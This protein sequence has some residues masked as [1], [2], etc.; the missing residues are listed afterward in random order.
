[1]EK[2]GRVLLWVGVAL[3]LL[4]IWL[5]AYYPN[6]DGPCHVANAVTMTDMWAHKNSVYHSFYTFNY[7]PSPNWLT[8]LALVALQ[9]LFSGVVAEKILLSIYV[10]FMVAGAR[11]L[12]RQMGN[13]IPLWPLVFLL[14][15]FHNAVPGGFYNFS[16]SVAFYM[17]LMAAWLSF[18]EKRIWGKAAVYFLLLAL[19]YF[20]HPVSFVFGCFS[21]AALG[22]TYIL[23]GQISLRRGEWRRVLLVLSLSVAPF[24]LM[25]QRFANDMGG[26][27]AIKTKFS[28]E[29][30]KDLAALKYLVNYSHKEEDVLIGIGILFCL[31][32]VAALVFRFRGKF[33][34]HHYDGFLL[35]LFFAF[36]VFLILPDAMLH[37]GYFVL[38]AGIFILLLVCICCAYIPLPARLLNG[39][40]ILLYALFA[41]LFF[42][43]MP[44]VF[45]AADAIADHMSAARYIKRG[46]VIL[47]LNYDTWGRDRDG[48]VITSRNNIFCH[49]AQYLTT[50]APTLVLDNYE[51]NTGYFP[52]NWRPDLDPF[53]HL[54]RWPGLQAGPPNAAI[55]EY[56]A[57]T[58]IVINN[59]LMM[60]FDPSF[61]QHETGKT[62]IAEVERDYHIVYTSPTGRT[63]LY[64][65]NK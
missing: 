7:T 38:R 10:L 60:N 33:K 62:L 53:V 46:A 22:L 11:R 58:G 59:V 5:P 56:R 16:F 54:A 57:K 29:R 14:L 63:I 25:F 13:T 36:T 30:L 37:G 48:K 55:E 26:L 42:V 28:P 12:L 64:E 24:V 18:L 47:P 3:C 35:T 49:M 40:A 41:I 6:C 19:T 50:S 45:K 44:I 20:S 31:L 1:M 32:L 43:R 15:I 61:R 51:A 27:E 23:S 34:V 21:S 52:L 8:A 4:Q 2:I 9:L 39:M 17:L 65:R